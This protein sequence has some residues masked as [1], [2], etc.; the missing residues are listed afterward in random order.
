M[1]KPAKIGPWGGNCGSCRDVRATPEQLVCV[2][3]TTDSICI[4]SISFYYGA[5]DGKMYQE[6]PWGSDDGSADEVNLGSWDCLR[7]IS[8]TTGPAYYTDNMLKSLT[9]VTDKGTYGPYGANEGT[10]FRIPVQDNGRIDGF[11]GRAGSLLDA[12]GIYV[13]PN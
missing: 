6:G 13:N 9:F 5:T 3:V 8:G 2:K 7:E 4:R 11:F 1:G 10:P 12:I